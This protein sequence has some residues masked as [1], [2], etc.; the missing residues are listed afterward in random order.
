MP[1]NVHMKRRVRQRGEVL[2]GAQIARAINVAAGAYKQCLHFQL[3]AL[4]KLL[5]LGQIVVAAK[6]NG[7]MFQLKG[8]HIARINLQEELMVIGGVLQRMAYQ[9]SQTLGQLL[10]AFVVVRHHALAERLHQLS[11]KGHYRK[12]LLGRYHVRLNDVVIQEFLNAQGGAVK[13]DNYNESIINGPEQSLRKELIERQLIEQRYQ[14]GLLKAHTF[15]CRRQCILAIRVDDCPALSTTRC[16]RK[17]PVRLCLTLQIVVA[18]FNG[19][20]QNLQHGDTVINFWRSEWQ[21]QLIGLRSIR[22]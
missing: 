21:R 17:L 22:L 8:M 18:L 15:A 7:L 9:A 6:G 5:R 2:P 19:Q 16:I 14:I 12:H 4:A 20:Q 1:N 10:V 11:K 3:D 13:Q